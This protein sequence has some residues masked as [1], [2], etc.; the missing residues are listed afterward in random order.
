MM[1]NERLPLSLSAVNRRWFAFSG[2]RLS[3]RRAAWLT[4]ALLLPISAVVAAAASVEAPPKPL[5]APVRGA[6][7][8]LSGSIA[9]QWLVRAH[10]AS[11]SQ[12]YTG[13]F[14]VLSA[15]GGMSSSRIWHA[16]EG[17]QQAERIEALSG[18]PR[19]VFRHNDQVATFLQDQRVVRVE[20]R[21]AYGLF[22][23]LLAPGVQ[24][25]GEHY[26]AL[27][28]SGERIAGQDTDVIELLPRDELRYGYRLW[29]EKRTGFAVRLQT[30]D[31]TGHVLEQAAF[32]ELDLAPALQLDKLVSM[33]AD[34]SGY[35]VETQES[36]SVSVD[37]EGWRMASAI[38]GFE[39][40]GAFRRESLT[41][42]APLQWIFSD[43]LATVSLFIEPY[44]TRPR[45]PWHMTN[46]V[47]H[48]LAEEKNQKWW[49]TAVGEVPAKTLK[50]FVS[51][52]QRQP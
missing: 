20:H 29:T 19:S 12:N 23:H 30:L 45:S 33:M 17:G 36:H 39:P 24:P 7:T 50:V 51:S 48:M 32:S 41:S 43:G 8:A 15:G 21:E 49:V 6:S 52:L 3:L 2:D 40:V 37:N 35:Q 4:L 25:V 31:K 18:T 46:G 27:H 26:E 38:P 13:T 14:V 44:G 22:P 47:T 1:G 42:G 11:S 34:T 28:K 10:D 5:A 9:E 16:A